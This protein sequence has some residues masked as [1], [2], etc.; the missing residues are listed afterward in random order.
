M[1]N[2]ILLDIKMWGQTKI[3]LLTMCDFIY[4]LIWLHQVFIAAHVVFVENFARL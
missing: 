4:L 2:P 1:D 3:A